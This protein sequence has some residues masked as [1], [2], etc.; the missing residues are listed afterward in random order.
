LGQRSW[1]LIVI[2]EWP[3]ACQWVGTYGNMQNPMVLDADRQG[4]AFYEDE[5]EDE[6]YE[7]Q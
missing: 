5:N 1:F 7:N 2:A 4:E 3:L 6:D